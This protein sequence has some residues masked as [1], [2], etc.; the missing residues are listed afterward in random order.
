MNEVIKNILTRTS[1]RKFTDQKIEEEKLKILVDCAKAAPTA[2]NRLARKFTII[3]NREKIQELAKAIAK[4]LNLENYRIYDCDAIILISFAEDDGF[5]RC[6]SACAIENIY[7]AAHSMGLGSVWINQ[8]RNK[9][10]ES[11]IRKVLDS[12]NI[13][14][15][16]IVCGF[17]ALGYPAE[18]PAV[19]E[20]TETAEFIK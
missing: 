14:K 6:D 16:H 20:R 15:N 17:S 12:F 11:E 18:K 1:I 3:Q 9:C 5:G 10:N 19:K 13:P 7:L 4:V 2:R 8:L